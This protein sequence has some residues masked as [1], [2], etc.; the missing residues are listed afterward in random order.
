MLITWRVIAIDSSGA[1]IIIDERLSEERAREIR[2]LMIEKGHNAII[3]T[4]TPPELNGHAETSS[5][6][7]QWSSGGPSGSRGDIPLSDHSQAG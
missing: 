1:R 2:D 7:I 4:E 3:E 5:V 6:P